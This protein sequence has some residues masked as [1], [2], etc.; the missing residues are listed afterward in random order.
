MCE[1]DQGLLK[2]WRF[3]GFFLWY[4]GFLGGGHGGARKKIISGIDVTRLARL[5]IGNG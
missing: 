4:F 3:L 1:S 5:G 2:F